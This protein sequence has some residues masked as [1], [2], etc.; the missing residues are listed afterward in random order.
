V[1]VH[2]TSKK[3][4][5][6]PHQARWLTFQEDRRCHPKKVYVFTDGS[7]GGFGAVV[8]TEVKAIRYAGVAQLTGTRNV[9]SEMN[10]LL[11]GL[12]NA[13]KRS[14]VVVVSDYLGVAAWMTG[15][16]KIKNDE[17]RDQVKRAKLLIIK[18]Q[19]KVSYC[20]HAGHQGDDSDFTRWNAEADRLAD[21]RV[22]PGEEFLLSAVDMIARL[23]DET[24]G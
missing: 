24:A 19:L 21:G 6:V 22:K 2:T 18:S 14:N 10:G 11:L 4:I 1:P 9:G 23:T 7:I 20:H 17:V 5:G 12:A 16:W 3:T 15:N 13:P 8:V